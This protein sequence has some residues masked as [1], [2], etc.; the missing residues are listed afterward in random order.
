M[1]TLVIAGRYEKYGVA[2]SATPYFIYG[3]SGFP[4]N[5]IPEAKADKHYL[6]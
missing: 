4:N 1:I 2:G 6:Y 3:D 5:F